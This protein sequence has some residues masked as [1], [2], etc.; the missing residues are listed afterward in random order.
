MV[1]PL[2][3]DQSMSPSIPA[4]TRL[5]LAKSCAEKIVVN[6]ILKRWVRYGDCV[7]RHD[8]LDCCQLKP[9]IESEPNQ[10]GSEP[11]V[12]RGHREV[13]IVVEIEIEPLGLG[14]PMLRECHF[15]AEPCGPAEDG[16][17]LR[18]TEGRTAGQ[19]AVSQSGTAEYEDVVHGKAGASAHGA[20][21]GIGKFPRREPI[22]GAG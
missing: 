11:V 7:V 5:W 22:V 18:R 13:A 19:F 6:E 12:R 10:I 2:M 1:V 14:R 21:P 8:R 16:M 9:I 20:E 4:T 15:S 17:T 3:P